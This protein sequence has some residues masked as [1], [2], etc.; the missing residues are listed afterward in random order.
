MRGQVDSEI[1]LR[2]I[3]KGAD[4]PMELAITRDIIRVRSVRSRVE[5]DDVGHSIQRAD[6]GR[7]EEGAKRYRGANPG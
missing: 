1:K 5:G 6:D 7:L 3:R 4:K 2:M